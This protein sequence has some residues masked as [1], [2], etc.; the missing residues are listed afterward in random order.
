MGVAIVPFEVTY[1]ELFKLKLLLIGKF[2][3]C[4]NFE[5]VWDPTNSGCISLGPSVREDTTIASVN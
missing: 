1:E 3:F 5:R 2:R 4:L